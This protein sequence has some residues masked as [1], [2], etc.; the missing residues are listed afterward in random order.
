VLGDD[1]N[2]YSIID[3]LSFLLESPVVRVNELSETEFSGNEDVLSTWELELSSS[4]GL[5][6]L[7]LEVWLSSNG[8]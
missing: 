8:K 7:G 5:L 2:R 6:S 4:E 1:L 3:D